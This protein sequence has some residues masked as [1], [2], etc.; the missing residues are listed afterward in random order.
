MSCF[1]NEF[2]KSKEFLSLS[3]SI[4]T[5]SAPIG[6]IGLT[7]ITKCFAVHALCE[8]GKK[9]LILTPDEASAVRVKENLSELQDG[10]LLYPSREFT[11]VEVA[12]VS[13]DFEHIRLGVLSKILEGDF[14][15]VVASVG[16]ACQFTMPADELKRRS[17]AVKVNDEIHME[18]LERQLVLAGYTRYDQVDGSSQ[19]AV[20][21]GII[22]IFPSYLDSPVRIELWGDTVD[23]ISPFDLDTQRRNGSLN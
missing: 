9:A 12:G 22:D 16:A 2:N 18:K 15:A 6:A 23:T 13:R 14:T 17:F 3:Q 8:K 21:G 11:F 20:R 10:V 1:S 7:D 5:L 4:D 19:F